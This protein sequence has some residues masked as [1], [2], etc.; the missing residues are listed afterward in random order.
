MIRPRE[1]V[2]V[3]HNALISAQYGMTATEQNIFC[4]LVRQI[5]QEDLPGK[6]YHIYVK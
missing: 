5:K 6:L 3:E 1:E 4:M 2:S